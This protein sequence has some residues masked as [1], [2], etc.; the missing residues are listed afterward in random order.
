[1]K[2]REKDI[3]GRKKQKARAGDRGGS[4]KQKE[5]DGIMNLSNWTRVIKVIEARLFWR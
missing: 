3:G 1:M 2:R 4:K 5:R